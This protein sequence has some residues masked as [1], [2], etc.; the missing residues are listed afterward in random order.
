V[1][2][3]KEDSRENGQ[4]VLSGWVT[5]MGIPCYVD[6]PSG[7]SPRKE[8]LDHGTNCGGRTPE[9]DHPTGLIGGLLL[10]K[11]SQ[12]FFFR[13]TELTS[14]NAGAVINSGTTRTPRS[15]SSCELRYDDILAEEATTQRTTI[16][17]ARQ[18]I[19]SQVGVII[20]APNASC[21]AA[22]LATK[23]AGVNSQSGGTSPH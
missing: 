20:A 15:P 2:T 6:P 1:R 21:V 14:F 23:P 4:A 12:Q 17:S 7:R 10:R 13:A 8:T 9:L 22:R 18:R 11:T 16:L 5:G 3:G 19:G